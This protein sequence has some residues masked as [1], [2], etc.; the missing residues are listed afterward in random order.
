[1]Q[2]NG[3]FVDT[4][5]E[6]PE[7]KHNSADKIKTC[8]NIY[9]D[10]YSSVYFNTMLNLLGGYLFQFIIFPCKDAKQM[11]SDI[12]SFLLSAAYSIRLKFQMK[13]MISDRNLPGSC[14][15]SLRQG[16]D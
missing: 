12:E 1:M 14:S 4:N 2:P 6:I 13:K 8:R 9:R 7:K 5:T 11:G 15:S 16:E 10:L 3:C